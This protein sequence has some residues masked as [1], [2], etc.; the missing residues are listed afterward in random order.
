MLVINSI[1]D[2]NTIFKIVARKCYEASKKLLEPK[3]LPSEVTVFN[4]KANY[5]WESDIFEVITFVGYGVYNPLSTIL[6]TQL[7]IFWYDKERRI[8]GRSPVLLDSLLE[9]IIKMVLVP[10]QEAC[11]SFIWG[12]SSKEQF[13]DI[14]ASMYKQIDEITFGEQLAI[15]WEN[16][17]AQRNLPI[18]KP[19]FNIKCNK[20]HEEFNVSSCDIPSHVITEDDFLEEFSDQFFLDANKNVACVRCHLNGNS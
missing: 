13:D 9:P 7:G 3:I 10:M 14:Y 6:R 8:R 1:E 12:G 17:K 4:K 5:F 11:R 19:L 18:M 15:T 20:C 16:I 2:V